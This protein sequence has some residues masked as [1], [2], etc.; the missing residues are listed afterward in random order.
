M[1]SDKERFGK[2][3]QI[4]PRGSFAES[5]SVA[6][7]AAECPAGASS[8]RFLSTWVKSISGLHLKMST[9]RLARELRAL[10]QPR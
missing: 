6:D 9:D 5:G 4:A 8:I 10:T 7:G 1:T 2:V 3:S